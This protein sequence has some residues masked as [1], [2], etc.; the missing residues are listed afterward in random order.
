MF[1]SFHFVR[2]FF[3]SMGVLFIVYE[4]VDFPNK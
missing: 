4:T 3:F 2:V 1:R